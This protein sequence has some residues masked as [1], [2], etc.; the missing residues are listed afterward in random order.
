MNFSTARGTKLCPDSAR[1]GT[2]FPGRASTLRQHT[3]LN[4]GTPVAPPLLE[5]HHAKKVTTW[6]QVSAV[7]LQPDLTRSRP[8]TLASSSSHPFRIWLRAIESTA[9]FGVIPL[10]FADALRPLS[11]PEKAEDVFRQFGIT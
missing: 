2:I 11:Q 8:T 9:R 6:K 7:A 3:M 5:G 4:D 10:K 1:K